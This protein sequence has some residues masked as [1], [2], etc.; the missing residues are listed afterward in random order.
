MEDMLLDVS[1]IDDDAWRSVFFGTR[2]KLSRFRPQQFHRIIGEGAPAFSVGL[3]KARGAVKAQA[4]RLR[5]QNRIHRM[6]RVTMGT[7]DRAYPTY[8]CG[9]HSANAVS[10]VS[11][12]FPIQLVFKSH[13]PFDRDQ[14]INRFRLPE[15]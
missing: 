14:L 13:A 9:A 4:R 1:V 5:I 7:R 2:G 3:K 15:H 12:Q 8:I 10:G 6:H 11:A